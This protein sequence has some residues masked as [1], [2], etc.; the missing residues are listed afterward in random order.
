MVTFFQTPLSDI[1]RKLHQ[2]RIAPQ[3]LQGVEFAPVLEKV[4]HHDI[5]T[6]QKDPSRTV[7]PFSMVDAYSFLP[8]AL[9]R[10]IGN[11]PQL[12][13]IIRAGKNQEVAHLRYFPDVQHYDP[14]A[15]LRLG[16]LRGQYCNRFRLDAV[17]P[18]PSRERRELSLQQSIPE[19][20]SLRV[21]PAAVAD[22]IEQLGL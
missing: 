13:S 6:V 16:R 2:R 8:E 18:L 11:R 3:P 9:G 1:G 7:V 17:F 12:H 10:G 21:Y 19:L 5:P 14:L 22:Q 20:P 4:M 15:F